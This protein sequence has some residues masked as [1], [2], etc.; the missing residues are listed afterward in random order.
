MIGKE[1]VEQAFERKF[2]EQFNIHRTRQNFPNNGIDNF[3][4]MAKTGIY[5][6]DRV[7]QEELNGGV[8]L[9]KDVWYIPVG[10]A[11]IRRAEK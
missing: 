2:S 10:G 1:G 5:V 7:V 3:E 4:N 11:V 9:K 8:D 6:I